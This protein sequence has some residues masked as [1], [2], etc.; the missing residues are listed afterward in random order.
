MT[1]EHLV[2]SLLRVESGD[3]QTSLP[4]LPLQRALK[5]QAREGWVQ[6]AS[7]LSSTLRAGASC[8]LGNCLDLDNMVRILPDPGAVM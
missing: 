7:T 5:Y 1:A 3:W 4:T 8:Q 2:L 6:L